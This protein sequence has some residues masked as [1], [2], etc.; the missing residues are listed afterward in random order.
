MLLIVITKRI[1]M[2]FN[3]IVELKADIGKIT[4]V[5]ISGPSELECI[6]NERI[7][8]VAEEKNTLYCQTRCETIRVRSESASCLLRSE[9]TAYSFQL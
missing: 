5:V 7:T 6:S 2:G 3:Q 8:T 1:W 9:N 4:G